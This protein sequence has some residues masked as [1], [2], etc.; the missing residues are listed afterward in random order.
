MT[1]GVRGVVAVDGPAGTGKSTVTR[2][3]ATALGARY[4]DTGAMYRAATLAV[5]RAGVDPNDAGKVLA[6]VEGTRMLVGT[7]PLGP[8]IELADPDPADLE[9]TEDVAAE[10]RGPEVTLAVSPVSAVP[11]VRELIVA[12]Q[13]QI[14]ADVVA[15]GGRIV[16]EGR[17]IGTTVAPAADLKIYLTASAEARAQRRVDQDVRAGRAASVEAVLAD[18]QRRDTYDSTRKTSPLRKAEDA[19]EVDTTEL[20]IDGVVA[21]LV[22]LAEQ[23]GLS[24]VPERTGP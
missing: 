4:L 9:R 22:E 16:A 7:D 15:A 23:A 12:Q 1:Q 13:Q 6:V 21:R 17:D 3:L 8:T 10:I 24:A 18:V 5:L 19:I 20:D 2:R 11:A 14:I